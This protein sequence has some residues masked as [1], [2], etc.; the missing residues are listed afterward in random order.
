MDQITHLLGNKWIDRYKGHWGS[1]IVLAQ[2]SHQEN[3]ENIE[4][5]IW[6][7]CVSYCRL[8]AITKLFQFPIPRCDDAITIL[9][10]GAGN[11]LIISL[12]VRQR[13]HQ[14]SVP[15][16]DREKLVFLHPMI[17]SIHLM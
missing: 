8:N 13:Y 1:M 2:K 14:I 4:D 5:F 11:I 6:R 9:G 7:M 3:I 10:N 12:D 17:E 16:V 15:E